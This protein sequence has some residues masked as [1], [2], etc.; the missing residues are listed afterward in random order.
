MESY[1]AD[2]KKLY[3]AIL[4]FLENSDE[5]FDDTTDEKYLERLSPITK[6]EVKVGD[7]ENMKGFLQ[8]IKNISD[9]HRRDTNFIT[10]TKQ[11]LLHFKSQ[12]KQTLSNEEIFYIFEANKL[13]VHFLLTN[14]FIRITDKICEEMMRKQEPNGNR[15]C[16]FF[17]PELEKF[18]GEEKMKS[19]KNELLNKSE[20]VFDNYELKRQEGEND[21][22]ICSMIRN[23][24]V[25]EFI[26]YVTRSNCSLSN[27]ITPSI[28]E[29]NPFLIE[30]K[31]TTQ[32]EYSAFF[33]S[34]RIFQY[35]MMNGVQLTAS[36]WLYAIHSKNA[37]LIHILEAKNVCPPKFEDQNEEELNKP[38]N[39]FL[40]CFIESIKCHHNDFADYIQNN[41]LFQEEKDP[42]RNETITSNYIKYHN[43]YYFE[44]ETI[45]DHGFFYLSLYKYNELF[46]LLLKEKEEGIKL[47][48]ISNHQYF[49]EE[50][51]H[52]K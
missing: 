29:T 43:Y 24:L 34:I 13:L 14:D 37:E 17:Y 18:L 39:G 45:K 30:R 42:K 44:T 19:V 16:H 7:C 8:I 49:D 23:D 52:V 5:N 48:I 36:L 28:F 3:S 38:N 21:S 40:R 15:Y 51:I 2:K 1:I 25:E 4:E 41:F 27:Q 33:G 22:L 46:N 26:S 10:R 32:I 6:K 47:R 20:N 9:E 12:I 31:D 50:L 11:L 35:L